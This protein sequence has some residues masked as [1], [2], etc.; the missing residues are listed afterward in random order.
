[1]AAPLVEC[2]PN[3]SEGRDAA[4]IARLA[5]AVSSTRGVELL[6]EH[7][8]SGAHRSVLT[9]VGPREPVLD[10]AF[11]LARACVSVRSATSAVLRVHAGP[12]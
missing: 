11:A 3:V 1:M 12:R 2:V 7:A 8:G 4:R 10:A 5:A 9:F 6:H